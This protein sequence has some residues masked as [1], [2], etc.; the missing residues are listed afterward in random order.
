MRLWHTDE[1]PNLGQSSSITWTSLSDCLV[2]HPGTRW[3]GLTLLQR[4]NRWTLQPQPNGQLET[5]GHLQSL[6][7]QRKTLL[8]R[9]FEKFARHHNYNNDNKKMECLLIAAKNMITKYNHI[10]AK[11]NKI[12]KILTFRRKTERLG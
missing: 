1:S 11:T 8:H 5:S 3:W 6:R 4:C 9:W 2:S 7:F 12:E 10:K